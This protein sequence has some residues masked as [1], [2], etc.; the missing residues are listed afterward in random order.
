MRNSLLLVLGDL[1]LDLLLGHTLGENSPTQRIVSNE[2]RTK[3][4][5]DLLV[6]GDLDL[7]LLS[8]RAFERSEVTSSLQSFGGDESLDLGAAES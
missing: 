7:L 1:N 8:L 5:S 3:A 6:F 4:K 2:D